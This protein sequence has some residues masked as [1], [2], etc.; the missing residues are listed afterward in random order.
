MENVTLSQNN[1]INLSTK[2]N[3]HINGNEESLE[4]IKTKG[5]I[6]KFKKHSRIYSD[7]CLGFLYLIKGKIRFFLQSLNAKE[8]TFFSINK[9]ESYILSTKCM[10]DYFQS[11]VMLEFI[12]DSEVFIIPNAIFEKLCQNNE[13][14]LQFNIAL[15]SRRLKQSINTIDDITFKS[16]KNRV[17]KYLKENAKDDAITI[18]QENLANHIGSAREAVSR[19]LKEL[20]NEGL[21]CTDRTQII[22]NQN[23]Y[24]YTM[25]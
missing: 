7:E 6:K 18:S 24:N 15:I 11:D 5:I 23:I 8:I 16:L 20:K 9:D 2:I 4:V 17:I 25:N 22:L 12:D 21:I 19:I 10:N 13:K 1:N 3:H 14:I